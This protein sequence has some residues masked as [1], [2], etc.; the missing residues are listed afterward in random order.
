MAKHR[1]GQTLRKR[2][3]KKLLAFLHLAENLKNEMRHSHTSKGRLE[4]VAEHSWRTVLIAVLLRN[5]LGNGL[6]WERLL[7]MIVIHDL[8][9][10][11]TGDVPIFEIRSRTDK[12]QREEA[13][14]RDFRSMLPD[15]M[16]S[17]LFDLW[18]EFESNQTRE[19]RIGHA[20]DKLEA[21]VQHNE[22]DLKTW[23]AW[24]KQRVFGGLDSVTRI[25]KPIIRFKNAVINE[26]VRKLVMAGEDI[27]KL[28]KHDPRKT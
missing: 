25:S 14:M 2:E 28:R 10:A 4:S 16:G 12:K 18:M 6:N 5:Y 22:A 9:E 20:L 7:A 3:A 1:S 13:A 8:A 23:L 19:A 11:R 21:Q 24:E 17:W 27:E 15:K 26:A